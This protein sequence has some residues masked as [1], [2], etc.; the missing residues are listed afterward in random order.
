MSSGK[1]PLA[2]RH[3]FDG[4]G[5]RKETDDAAFAEAFEHQFGLNDAAYAAA[6][7]TVCRDA[8]KLLHRRAP[9]G[10]VRKVGAQ[11]FVG[12]GD[13]NAAMLLCPQRG[14]NSFRFEQ[15]LQRGGIAAEQGDGEFI[16]L[17]AVYPG[18][19]AALF[20]ERRMSFALL[21]G[22]ELVGIRSNP[23]VGA[24]AGRLPP[25]AREV[26]KQFIPRR[27]IVQRTLLLAFPHAGT[28]IYPY[29]VQRGLRLALPFIC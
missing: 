13:G 3:G 16:A 11:V 5:R 28:V 1:Q 24:S 18:G 23:N 25:T 8:L 22:C 17:H 7:V 15:G 29:F 9:V 12:D 21:L 10:H 19:Y 14:V 27:Q 2:K 6:P 26:E 4:P 20:D